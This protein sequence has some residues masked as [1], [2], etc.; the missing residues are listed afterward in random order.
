MSQAAGVH[1]GPAS[2]RSPASTLRRE[3]RRLPPSR[4]ALPVHGVSAT[5]A[6]TPQAAIST[7]QPAGASIPRR[8]ISAAPGYEMSVSGGT[9]LARAIANAFSRPDR[10]LGAG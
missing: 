2:P 5:H 8:T 1:E 10:L 4:A 7:G 6:A 9:H 3:A